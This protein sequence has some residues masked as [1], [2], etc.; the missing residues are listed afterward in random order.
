MPWIS[1]E[2]F[3]PSEVSA[4]VQHQVYNGLDCCLTFEIYNV[5]GKMLQQSNDPAA[6]DIYN[7]ERAM[8]APALD[9]ME[10]GFRVDQFERMS[11][12]AELQQK[13]AQVTDLLN[14]L[15]HVVWGKGLNPNSPAQMKAFFY[16]TNGLAL[17]EQ[18]K[19]EKGVRKVS[20]NR[21]ALEK[22]QS[23]FYARPIINCCLAVKDYAKKISVLTK[24]VDDDKRM[25][26]SY[27][28]AGT[29][30][31]RW[32]SSTSAF[33]TGTNLQN[34]TQEL[35]RVFIADPGMKLCYLDLE[36]AESFVVG[37]VVWMVTGDETYLNACESGDLHTTTCKLIWPELGWTS[38][39]KKDR[40]IAEQTFYR[41]FS[42]RDMSK[43]GGHGTNYYG[44]PR[45]MARHLK[46]VTALMEEFRSKY[47]SAYPGIPLWHS[48]TAKQ[49]SLHNTLTTPLGRKR[50]FFG[51][52]DDDATL[53]EAIAYVPQSTVADL[54]NYI[55]YTFWTNLRTEI[56]LLAQIHDAIVFQF[57]EATETTIVPKALTLARVPITVESIITPGLYRTI[58]I[59]SEAKIGWN[60]SD[61]TIKTSRGK[62]IKN[63]NGLIK[64]TGKAD[65]RKRLTGLH[66]PVS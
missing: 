23:Y 10:R 66:R 46:V 32:S 61:E 24:E 63:P 44:Q 8:Q 1:T 19:I 49:L 5:I 21:D 18:H 37:L 17:P 9:M 29:E 51:R 35:R 54:L 31:G 2:I 38:E 56:Q 6:Q 3:N 57:P 62:K 42:Y 34:I 47:F 14:K 39:K 20:T 4:T 7:F 26:T 45:T 58:I 65:D 50:I 64:W 30:S 22:L 60:W 15:A 36:Q 40:E 41:N 55:L 11:A 48:W 59:P 27:N 13:Q 12:V 33:G 25:R 43:R 16:G 53:R 52:P 28:I